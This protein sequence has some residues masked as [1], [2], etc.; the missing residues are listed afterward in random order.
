MNGNAS[1][2]FVESHLCSGSLANCSMSLQSKNLST[3]YPYLYIYTV[4]LQECLLMHL[5][6]TKVVMSP[7]QGSH[8]AASVSDSPP[9]NPPGSS[10]LRS[11]TP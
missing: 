4:S 10:G 5:A 6:L 8:L 2:V 9:P 1:R 11:V 3:E 7:F